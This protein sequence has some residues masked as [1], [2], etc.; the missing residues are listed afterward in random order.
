[1]EHEMKKLFLALIVMALAGCATTGTQDISGEIKN[2]CTIA[3]PTLSSLM[4]LES[5]FTPTKQAAINTAAAT[6]NTFCSA[7]ITTNQSAALAA[8][9]ALLPVLV[10]LQAK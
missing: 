10:E 8:L 2:A 6:V 7:T 5:S 3:Q 4:A 1:M 9:T